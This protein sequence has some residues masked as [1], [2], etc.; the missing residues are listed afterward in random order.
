M[1]PKKKELS[2]KEGK[3][4]MTSEINKEKKPRTKKVPLVM[5]KPFFVK[6]NN[7]NPDFVDEKV[8]GW[9]IT[10][11]MRKKGAVIWYL[12]RATGDVLAS[13][14]AILTK[15]S[16][17]GKPADFPP[18]SLS[19]NDLASGRYPVVDPLPAWANQCFIPKSL[20]M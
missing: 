14:D 16:G 10:D 1:A 20:V 18:A 12:A 9:V 19:A 8:V 11:T 7:Q 4:P 15:P 5:L 2:K 13:Q 17:V 3:M 6:N